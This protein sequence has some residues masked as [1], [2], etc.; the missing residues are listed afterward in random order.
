MLY[1]VSKQSDILVACENFSEVLGIAWNI[2]R[3]LK[4]QRSVGKHPFFWPRAKEENKNMK[5]YIVRIIILGFSMVHSPHSL[6]EMTQY[7][8][9]EKNSLHFENVDRPILRL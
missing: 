7:W 1:P 9:I 4:R 3:L 6:A 5:R 8:S 2:C